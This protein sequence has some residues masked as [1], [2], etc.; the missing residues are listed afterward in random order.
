MVIIDSKRGVKSADYIEMVGSYNPRQK[1]N[2]KIDGERVKYWI[3]VGAKPTDTVHNLLINEKV[4]EGKKVNPLG[5]KTP[6]AN[7]EAADGSKDAKAKPVE[8]SVEAT[9]SAEADSKPADSGDAGA[10]TEKDAAD[11]AESSD[12]EEPKEEPAKEETKEEKPAEEA[13]EEKKDDSK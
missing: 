9:D 11:T 4:I 10:S 3:S 6:I 2:T 5:K 13:E 1:G 8:D 12:K 7:T